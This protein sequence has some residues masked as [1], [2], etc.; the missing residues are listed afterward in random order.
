MEDS[1]SSSSSRDRGRDRD[2]EGSRPLIER[3]HS[4]TDRRGAADMGRD[5]GRDKDRGRGT[6]RVPGMGALLSGAAV[7]AVTITVTTAP[8]VMEVE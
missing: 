7:K 8:I 2:R 6:V 1:S 4:S 3:K 5:K